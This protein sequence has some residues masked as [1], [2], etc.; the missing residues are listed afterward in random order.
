MN[1][2]KPVK[3]NISARSFPEGFLWGAATSA[4][5]IEGS[6][7]ADGAGPSNWYRYSH[8][9]GRIE[10]GSTGDIACDHYNRFDEDVALMAELGLHAYRFSISWSR[11]LPEGRGP[12]NQRGLDFYQ[13]L[14]DALLAR[15]IQ[16]CPT[17]FHWDLPAAL[18]D[19]GGWLNRDLAGYFADYAA[20]VFRALSDR[21]RF[22]MTINEPWVVVDAGYL[23]GVHAPGHQSPFEAPRAAHNLLRAHGAAVQA[24]RARG[25]GQIGLVVNLE[26]KDCATNEAADLAA[27]RRAHAYMN[28]QFL[29][30]VFFG[31][32]PDGLAEIFGEAWPAPPAEDFVLIRQPMDFLAIN[33]YTR[34]VNQ[35]DPSRPPVC[36]APVRQEGA[37]YTE[38]GWEVH[39][40]SLTRVLTWVRDRYGE[41]PLYITENG[42]AF[43]D[44]DQASTDPVE[45]PLRVAY[46]RD[47]LG[48]A[49]AAIDAGVDLRGYFVWSL[50][51]NLEWAAGFQK[52]FGIVHVDFATL[53]RTW[54][55]S[56]RVYREVIR[57]NGGALD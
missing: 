13:R 41:I 22:W 12:I 28:E 43:S 35:H 39:A 1:V 32:Y 37:L 27:T 9:P 44:P 47:H 10:D 57:S 3:S 7:L 36:A 14:V 51:D 16:P 21:V 25:A 23:H 26:P 38:T 45:D 54:K 50:L 49:R 6:L 52:R 20:V 40:E 2:S 46:L 19:I 29:D 48:A 30:P 4:F 17:L 33:Y 34:S 55:R 31:R 8:S 42:A 24:C 56:A 15:G 5:Q 18:D 53:K 11:I